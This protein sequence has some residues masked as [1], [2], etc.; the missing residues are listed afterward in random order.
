M[1]GYACSILDPDRLA[2]QG[3][4]PDI[5]FDCHVHNFCVPSDWGVRNE[6]LDAPE[7]QSTEPEL[8][9][10][11][12]PLQ[13]TR[14]IGWEPD[15]P[16]LI[17]KVVASPPGPKPLAATQDSASEPPVQDV[18]NFPEVPTPDTAVCLFLNENY[19]KLPQSPGGGTEPEEAPNTRI[20]KQ[21]DLKTS[22]PK[23]A[24]GKPPALSATLPSKTPDAKLP[25][26]RKPDQEVKPGSVV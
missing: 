15:N 17:Y 14:P 22:H 26:P 1:V 2:A 25:K 5:G 11:Q 9:P 18:G 20:N 23:A 12:N 3:W 4:L 7:S 21:K 13:T 8:N 6:N 16:L 24:S 19:S 10:G